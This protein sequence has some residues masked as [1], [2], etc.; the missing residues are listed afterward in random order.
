MTREIGS[1]LWSRNRPQCSPRMMCSRDSRRGRRASVMESY[2]SLRRREM[3]RSIRARCSRLR[4]CFKGL[5]ESTSRWLTR[6]STRISKTSSAWRPPS[7]S[8]RSSWQLLNSR[9]SSR[10]PQKLDSNHRSR[11]QKAR[12]S[13][14]WQ[15]PKALLAC[16]RLKLADLLLVALKLDKWVVSCQLTS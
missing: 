14:P 8:L 16:Y 1:R 6:V 9:F 3:S 13:M 10:L 2:P 15:V 5:S 4:M 11:A 12:L 7:R